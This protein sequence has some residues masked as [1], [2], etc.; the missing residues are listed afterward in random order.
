MRGIFQGENEILINAPADKVWEILRNSSLMP[1]WLSMVRSLNITSENKSE[2]GEVRECKVM[3]GKKPGEIVERCIEFIPQQKISYVVDKDSFGFTRM[4]SDYGFSYLLEE[5]TNDKTL[6]RMR[7]YYVPKG[8]FNKIMNSLM[9]KRK[10]SETRQKI[11]SGL[12]SYIEQSA[13]VKNDA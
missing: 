12:K 10:F 8:L 7:L 4:F 1:E 3:F 11:L 13:G 2:V 5:R 9:M 6:C